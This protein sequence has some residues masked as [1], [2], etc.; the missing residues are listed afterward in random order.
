MPV[1][2]RIGEIASI[3]PTVQ[4]PDRFGKHLPEHHRVT[5]DEYS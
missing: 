4:L 1:E 3:P 2:F 5:A